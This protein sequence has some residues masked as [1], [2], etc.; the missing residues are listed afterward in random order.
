MSGTRR[1]ATAPM[2]FTPPS[3]MRARNR[4][5]TRP[6]TQVGTEKDLSMLTAM[7]LTCTRLPMPKQAMKPKMAKQVPSHFHFGPRPFLM[8]YMAPPTQR[9]AGVFSRYFTARMI[10]ENLVIMPTRAVTHIQKR[11]PG[12]PMAIAVATPT[13]LPVPISPARAVMSAFQGE[14]S[15]FWDWCSRPCQRSL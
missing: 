13:M 10:S 8:K 15:P 9:P 3:R 1:P 5:R 7:A 11:A 4:S 2:R 12:P 14:I 6:V